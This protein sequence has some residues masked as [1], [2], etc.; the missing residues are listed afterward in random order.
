MDFIS[1]GFA[2]ASGAL[3]GGISALIFS[4]SKS[5]SKSIATTAVTVILFF[6]FN[7]ISEQYISPALFPNKIENDI[8]SALEQIPVYSSIKKYEPETYNSM[9]ETYIDATRKSLS[10]QKTIDL[11]RSKLRTVVISRLKDASDEAIVTYMGVIVEEIKELETMRNDLCFKYLFPEVAGGINAYKIFSSSMQQKDL[12][13][14]DEIIKTSNTERPVPTEG[15]IMPL[16]Q[17][18]FASLYEKYGDDVAMLDNPK[19][20]NVDRL[21][22]CSITKDLYIQLLELPKEQSAITLRWMFSQI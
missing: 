11:M 19:G 10:K 21:K 17:P 8:A 9:I 18:I 5:K 3:A 14:L 13:A 4:K 22:I 16:L 15:E 6:V 12:A 2:A 20:D 7:A 1:V